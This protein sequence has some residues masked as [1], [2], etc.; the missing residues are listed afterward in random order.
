MTETPPSGSPAVQPRALNLRQAAV[1]LGLSS[2]TLRDYVL[3][4][5]IPV[6]EFPPLRPREGERQRS[7]LRRVLVDREDLDRFLESRKSGARDMESR[8]PAK[9]SSIARANVPV[10]CPEP[11]T[12]GVRR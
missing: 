6:V 11:A 9:P 7:T 12:A 5:L 2:W 4:G 3:A 10:L 8:A 1:Y